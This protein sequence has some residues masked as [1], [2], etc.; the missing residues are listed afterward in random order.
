[1]H[2]TNLLLVALSPN[3]CTSTPLSHCILCGLRHM[4][5]MVRMINNEMALTCIDVCGFPV[6]RKI[7]FCNYVKY[8]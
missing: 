2:N 1:M 6:Q 4:E 3:H 7:W 5:E 8:M